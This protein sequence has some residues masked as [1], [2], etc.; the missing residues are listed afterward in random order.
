[1]AAAEVEAPGADVWLLQERKLYKDVELAEARKSMARQGY[2]AVFASGVFT[3]AGGRSSGTAVFFSH[4]AELLHQ[5]G[6][7]SQLASQ[8]SQGCQD[9]HPW[10]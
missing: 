3:E 4:H 9:S 1:M 10:H 8:P 6:L 2:T 7:D 5:Q